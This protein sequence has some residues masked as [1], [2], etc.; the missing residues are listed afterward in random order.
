MPHYFC[1]LTPPRPGFPADITPD[2]AALMGTHAAYWR[3]RMDEGAVVVFGPV[4]D[5]AGAYGILVLQLPEGAD[6][7]PLVDADPVILAG[8]GFRFEVHPM[9]AVLPAG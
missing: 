9:R 1:K 2:E 7:Q 5:P 6:P 3:A 8:A 4:S